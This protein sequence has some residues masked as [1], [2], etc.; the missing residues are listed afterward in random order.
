MVLFERSVGASWTEAESP[1]I[2][3][4]LQQLLNQKLTVDPKAGWGI[5]LT[6][7]HVLSL[8]LSAGGR[9][10]FGSAAGQQL[11]SV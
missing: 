7:T 2:S 10:C 6:H 4:S 1:P 3:L 11:D 8:P 9:G 5:A